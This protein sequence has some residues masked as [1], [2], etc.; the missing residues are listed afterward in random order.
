M[1]SPLELKDIAG[2]HGILLFG[3]RARTLD[4]QI[5]VP[6]RQADGPTSFK[7]VVHMR[8]NGKLIK[9]CET[10]DAFTAIHAFNDPGLYMEYEDSHL[11]TQEHEETPAPA[12]RKHRL[13]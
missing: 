6:Q 9:V 13:L 10:T 2:S 12:K 3:N 11:L 8:K 1:K 7:F 4:L 5:N